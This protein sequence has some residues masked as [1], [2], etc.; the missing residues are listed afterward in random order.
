MKRKASPTGG[1]VGTNNPHLIPESCG[2]EERTPAR[3]LPE[4]STCRLA[5]YPDLR[6]SAS[7]VGEVDEIPARILDPKELRRIVRI[8]GRQVLAHCTC[9]QKGY[10]IGCHHAP[11]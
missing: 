4:V 7:Q 3:T 9:D 5:Q 8:T 2:T 11:R 6:P 1:P 10:R